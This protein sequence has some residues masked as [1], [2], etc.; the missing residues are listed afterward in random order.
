MI[1]RFIQ[2]TE[3]E[4]WLFDDT[5]LSEINYLNERLTGWLD[6]YNTYRPHQSLK[7]LTPMEYYN[8]LHVK[9]SKED[10]SMM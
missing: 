10:V 9:L 2:T 6:R 5:M 1:E 3:T 7:Y 8:S 4:L